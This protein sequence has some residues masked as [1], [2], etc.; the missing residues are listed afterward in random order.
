MCFM[1]SDIKARINT[2]IDLIDLIDTWI[3]T[4]TVKPN[5]EIKPNS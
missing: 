1:S 2:V 5:Q 3:D 4:L